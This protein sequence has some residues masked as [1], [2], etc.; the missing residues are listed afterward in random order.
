MPA[1]ERGDSVTQSQLAKS[2]GSR[3]GEVSATNT[4]LEQVALRDRIQLDNELL[5]GA[6]CYPA[7][8]RWDRANPVLGQKESG[9]SMGGVKPA[10]R[11]LAT[12]G[13]QRFRR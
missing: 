13:N 11:L 6:G 10:S 9:L 7:Y 4:A 12:T 2:S 8:P 1:F 5:H 3:S